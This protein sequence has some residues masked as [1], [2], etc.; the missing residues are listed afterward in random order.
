MCPRLFL[1]STRVEV[2]LV[3]GSWMISLLT[4][5]KGCGPLF[6]WPPQSIWEGLDPEKP[7]HEPLALMLALNYV[8]RHAW[9]LLLSHY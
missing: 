8:T 6:P 4:I 2:V 1:L 7:E 5:L 9:E 3:L